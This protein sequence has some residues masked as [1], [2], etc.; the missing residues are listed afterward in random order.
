MYKTKNRNDKIIKKYFIADDNGH[1]Y[2][3]D[4]TSETKAHM[5]LD[6]YKAKNPK[7]EGIEVLEHV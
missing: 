7:V 4:I 1:I 6:E 5:L 2:A 3:H